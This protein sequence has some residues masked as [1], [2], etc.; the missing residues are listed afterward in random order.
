MTPPPPVTGLSL[1]RN[2]AQML[3]LI[4]DYPVPDGVQ[5]VPTRETLLDMFHK[6]QR[7]IELIEHEAQRPR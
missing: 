4:L 1:L 2:T 5:L 6:L 3:G 7:G